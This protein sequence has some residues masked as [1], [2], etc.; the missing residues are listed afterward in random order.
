[1]KRVWGRKKKK[2]TCFQL[3]DFLSKPTGLS[4][5]I[6]RSGISVIKDFSNSGI[7]E[8]G[9]ES[10]LSMV[11]DGDSSMKF[12][13]TLIYCMAQS[14]SAGPVCSLYMQ[15]RRMLLPHEVHGGGVTLCELSVEVSH[16]CV[17]YT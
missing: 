8:I 15:H 11:T 17:L 4:Q 1:M 12:C 14:Y 10:L 13:S 2:K 7:L 9:I 6:M 16:G 3:V 5:S